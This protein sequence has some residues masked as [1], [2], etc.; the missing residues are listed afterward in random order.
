M[1]AAFQHLH[2]YRLAHLQICFLQIEEG[3]TFLQHPA[4]G[5]EPSRLG[6]G[7]AH[8]GREVA[9]D[10]IYTGVTSVTFCPWLPECESKGHQSVLPCNDGAFTTVKLPLL[11]KVLLLQLNDSVLA[12]ETRPYASQ[13]AKV[14]VTIKKQARQALAQDEDS[15]DRR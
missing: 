8:L 10:G 15:P 1:Q 4:K 12:K 5:V 7:G 2:Q 14:Y 3:C 6:T 11:S 13:Q 9:P